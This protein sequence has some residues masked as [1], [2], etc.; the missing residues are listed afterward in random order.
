MNDC[1]KTTIIYLVP[2][3]IKC[4]PINVVLNIVRRLE[5]TRFRP[6]VVALQRHK[7][8]AKRGNRTEFERENIEVVEY[9]Y[10]HWQLQMQT[11]RIAHRLRQTLPAD[12]IF[13][14]H[15]Y[16]PALILSHL[17]DRHTMVTI[18]NI[19]DEDFRLSKGTVMG[20]YMSVTYKQALRRIGLCITICR[21]MQD[22]YARDPRL[23]ICT[24]LNGVPV[25]ESLPTE[26]QRVS[27]RHELDIAPRTRALLYPAV[28]NPRKNH[29]V[30]I[31]SLRKS[32]GDFVVLMA[33]TGTTLD[34]CRQL[35]AGDVRFRFLGYRADMEVIWNAADLM[36]S[37]SL[38][39][40]LP[41]AVLEAC[42]HGLPCL[43]SNIPPHIE[44]A[45]NI[46]GAETDMLLFSPTD[47]D[48]LRHTVEKNINHPFDRNNIRTRV[49]PL[50]GA[51][52]MA[53]GYMQLYKKYQP[54]QNITQ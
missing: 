47:S 8:E 10:T 17:H 7:L 54:S 36:I 20:H 22:F 1:D 15:G 25:S 19:C 24:V 16:Y 29:A 9:E 53:D 41:L 44:I 46:F 30:L 51:Q 12:A 40:G 38:S 23:R 37:P 14:A 13:H 45:R 4:G 27:A 32:D 18:H 6:V 3:L 31:D 21:T 39:E 5:R 43:L 52:A 50:Y 28:F 34:E 33:G 11:R 26:E 49:I 2:S 48:G 35:A 42:A